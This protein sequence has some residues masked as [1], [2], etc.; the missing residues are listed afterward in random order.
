MEVGEDWCN[1]CSYFGLTTM[2]KTLKNTTTEFSLNLG[3]FFLVVSLFP[4]PE[5]KH[6]IINRK[7]SLSNVPLDNHS[8]LPGETEQGLK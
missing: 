4:P 7:T 2:W 8:N 5:N 1:N 6:S 3:I